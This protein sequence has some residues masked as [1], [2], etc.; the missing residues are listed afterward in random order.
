MQDEVQKAH[1]VALVAFVIIFLI[2]NV[3]ICTTRFDTVLKNLAD[4]NIRLHVMTVFACSFW[5]LNFFFAVTCVFEL[6]QRV[7]I[8]NSN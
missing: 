8:K 2:I 5:A 4:E 1:W 6:L 7:L 3:W